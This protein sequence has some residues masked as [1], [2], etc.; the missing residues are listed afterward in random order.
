V[1]TDYATTA[2]VMSAAGY[3]K[4][5]AG[6]QFLAFD[7]AG[8]GRAIEAL[9]D[10]LTATRVVVLVPGNDIT[11]R[12]YDDRLAAHARA[13]YDAMGAAAMDNDPRVAVVAWLGYD[14]PEGIWP[15]ALR[16]DR[17]ADGATALRV[18]LDALPGSGTIVLVGHSYGSVVVALAT[19]HLG[20]RVTDIVALASPGMGAS[21]VSGLHTHARVWTA[22]AE[23]DWIHRVPRLRVAGLGH[24]AVPADARVLPADG[25]IRHD[26][27]LVPGSSTLEALARLALQN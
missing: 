24:G 10:L 17:A 8:D 1:S 6:R 5:T 26:G 16:E 7:P 12:N 2:G 13:L 25:V 22:L 14:P 9:G 23:G 19:P 11:L 20:P 18:F 21:R 3:G 15:D 4:L 27:Y